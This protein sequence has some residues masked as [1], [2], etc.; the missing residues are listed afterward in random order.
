MT[1]RKVK[2]LIIGAGPAGLGAAYR[3]KELGEFDFHLIE[4]NRWV[5]GLAASFVD[6]KGF[7]W[8]IGGHVQFSHYPYFDAVMDRAL[9]VEG[10]LSHERESWVWMKERF[11]PYPF[12]NNI[13]YLPPESMWRCLKGIIDITKKPAP[14]PTDFHEWVMSIFGEGIAAEFMVPYNFKVWAYPLKEMAFQWIGERVSVVDL[15]RVARNIALGMDDLSW[16]PNNLFRFPL[17]GGTGAIWESVGNL[18]GL[19]RVSLRTSVVEI[20]PANKTAHLSNGEQITYTH[21]LSTMPVDKLATIV[22][23]F[24]SDLVA[25]AG[26]LKHSTSNIIGIGIKGRP[27]PALASKCW[28]YFPEDNCPFYRVTLFSKYS[29]NNVPDIGHYFSLMTET[30]ESLAK[31]VDQDRLVADTI[32]G[33]RATRLLGPSDEVVST[34]SYR[35][36]YGYPTPSLERDSIL[37]R[38]IPALED[39]SIYSRGR[40]GGWKY[41]VSNQDHTFMQGVEWANFIA[42]GTPEA[43]YHVARP[44]TVRP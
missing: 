28:M 29:P 14:P 32:A 5:G 12:Q 18:V 40:F 22:R 3:F 16:G 24:P 38:V 30:S 21:L 17:R 37:N 42:Q 4:S 6:E 27:A 43:T 33:L 20:D 8:D 41:E 10:W 36:E 19:D 35:A 25:C 31:P 39:L 13:R 34:W 44:K 11:I 9:G 26:R 15:E 1:T 7:T 2:Y 23:G